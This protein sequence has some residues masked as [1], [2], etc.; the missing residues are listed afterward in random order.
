MTRQEQLKFC[1]VCQHKGFN[2][3]L[4]IICNLTSEVASFEN[5]CENYIVD[6]Q[7]AALENYRKENKTKKVKKPKEKT[8]RNKEKLRTSDIYLIIGFSIFSTFLIRL[9]LYAE[10]FGSNL[11]LGFF[12]LS[13]TYFIVILSMQIKNKPKRRIKFFHDFKFK[14]VYSFTV[15][16]FYL[17]YAVL[18]LPHTINNVLQI[19][20]YI[21]VIGLIASNLSYLFMVPINY[22]RIKFSK[23]NDQIS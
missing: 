13:I 12:S 1:K 22:I 19:C 10:L 8:E 7:I 9:T 20:L 5:T 16:L 14:T 18:F 6:E 15:P 21:L 2:P 3:K 4:G 11:P 23:T 17:V